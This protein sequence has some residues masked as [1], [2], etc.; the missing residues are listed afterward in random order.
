MANFIFNEAKRLMLVGGLNL[1]SDSLKLLPVMSNS[2]ADANDDANTIGDIVTLD[3]L[4]GGFVAGGVALTSQTVAEDAAGNR[5]YFDAADVTMTAVAAGT[6]QVKGLILYKTG[7]SL[8]AGI[9]I[10][11]IDTPGFPFWTNGSNVVVTWS[12]NGIVDL[13]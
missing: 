11:W 6:R 4:D 2:T 1:S 8:N 13:V 7:A 10:A 5:A 3:P 9:P 12:A